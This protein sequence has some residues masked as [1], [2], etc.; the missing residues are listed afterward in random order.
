MTGVKHHKWEGDKPDCPPDPNVIVNHRQVNLNI[1]YGNV[2]PTGVY[3]AR[4]L[5]TAHQTPCKCDCGC[6]CSPKEEV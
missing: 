6:T 2:D 1:D 5:T 3:K 4:G